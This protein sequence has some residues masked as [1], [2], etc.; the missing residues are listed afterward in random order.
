MVLSLY[1]AHACKGIPI[2]FKEWRSIAKG[3]AEWRSRMYSK[4][5]ASTE[6]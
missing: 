3:R 1:S 4:R 2:N 6:D 5:I